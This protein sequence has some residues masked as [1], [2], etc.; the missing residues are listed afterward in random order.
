MSR[1]ILPLCK[2]SLASPSRAWQKVIEL[3]PKTPGGEAR[4]NDLRRRALGEAT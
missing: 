4:L 2:I 3:D 1:E